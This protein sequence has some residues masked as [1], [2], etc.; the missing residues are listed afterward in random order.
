[1]DRIARHVSFASPADADSVWRLAW[2][3]PVRCHILLACVVLFGVVGHLRYLHD[4]C[5]IDLSGDE[6]QY[7]DWSRQI[8]WSYYS[9]GPG[10]AWVIR[11]S[12]AIFGDNMPAVRYPAILLGAGTQVLT[13]LLTRRLFASER[14]ALGVVLLYHLAPL[15]VAGSVLM[16]IDPPFYFCWALATYLA[17]LALFDGRRWAWPLVGVVAGVGFLCKYAMLLWFAPLLL[18]MLIDRD[19]RRHLRSIGPWSAIAIA[20][21]LATPVLA[22]NARHD[23]VSFQHVAAQTGATSAARFKP[24]NVFAFVG[25][26][27]GVLG[28]GLFVI[29]AFASAYALRPWGVR[30]EPHARGLRFLACIG[31]GFLAMTM[32]ASL[33]AK[34][35]LNWPAPAYFTLMIVTAHFLATRLRSRSTWRP[36]RP[37][38]YGSAAFGLMMVPLAHDVEPLYPLIGWTNEQLTAWKRDL[39]AHRDNRLLAWLE[40]RMPKAGL[41]ARKLDFAA[42][43]K[44]WEE[45]GGR[46]SQELDALGPGAF[47]LCDD[48]QQTAEMAFYVRGQPKTFYAGSHYRRNPKRMTQYDLWPDRRLAPPNPR[49]GRNAIYLGHIDR[50]TPDLLAAFDRVE[51]VPD[52]KRS[53]GARAVEL[54]IERRGQTVQT[55]RYFRCYGFKGMTPGRGGR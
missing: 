26:Q 39:H 36:W 4:H 24:G 27:A 38:F 48:Y 16:T 45:L 1:M 43:L 31:L 21:L 17:A 20:L 10:V 12:C 54:A 35:Q 50:P 47:V 5:P 46:F 32:L 55:F 2:L 34:V 13:Y 53:G 25:G 41:S 28:P 6:A 49:V 52:P 37:W 8:D 44:G 33:R 18:F 7:W 23:W 40:R 3:T 15:F 9:K 22:W 51:G 14:L 11:A 19:A 42:K 30:P 29:M